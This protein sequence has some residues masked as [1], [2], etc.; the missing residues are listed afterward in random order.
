MPRPPIAERLTAQA[1][2]GEP[3]GSP[4]AVAERLLAVQGQDPR[5]RGWRSGLA[6]PASPPLMS[7]GP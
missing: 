2:S 3:L 7:I 5:E 6:P 1:L 4:E